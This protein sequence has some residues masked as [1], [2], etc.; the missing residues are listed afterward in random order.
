MRKLV[1]F[2]DII[3]FGLALTA[4][5]FIMIISNSILSSK[6]L[7]KVIKEEGI[8]KIVN[9]SAKDSVRNSIGNQLNNYPGVSI[10]IN[11]LI[12]SVLTEE[13]LEKEFRYIVDNL[14]STGKLV[15]DPSILSEGYKKNF[16]D[17]IASKKINLPEQLKNEITSSMVDNSQEK[18]EVKEFN[19]NFSGYVIK[20]NDY[21]SKIK[22]ISFSIIVA[23]LGLTL[24]L[25]KEKI[26]LIYKPLILGAINLFGIGASTKLLDTIMENT[27]IPNELEKIIISIKNHL[28]TEFIKYGIIFVV[29]AIILIII[30]IVLKKKKQYTNSNQNVVYDQTQQ[31][32]IQN[33]QQQPAHESQPVQQSIEQPVQESQNDLQ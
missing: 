19:D 1:A 22:I 17:Y 26:K 29:I 33:I 15:V 20:L 27:S 31:E 18:I 28:F 24:V 6:Y 32:Q 2:F 13:V 30:R 10:N 7:N 8:Y 3:I 12:D 16:E 21:V 23:L 11:E 25:S 9:D 4:F 5:T 14:Y